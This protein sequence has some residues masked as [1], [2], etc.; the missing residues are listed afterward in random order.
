MM[1]HLVMMM[2]KMRKKIKVCID[3]ETFGDDD[4]ENEEED[5]DVYLSIYA[6]L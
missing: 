6:Y 3:D 5:Q 1:K 4:K 2:R